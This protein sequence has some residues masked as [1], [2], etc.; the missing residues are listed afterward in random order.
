MKVD[1]VSMSWSFKR[2]D[3]GGD[4]SEDNFVRELNEAA[5]ANNIILFASLPD[6]GATA[7]IAKYVP[8]ADKNVIRIGSATMFGEEAKEIILA[9]RDFLLPGEEIKTPSGETDKG[10][11]YATAY[12]AGLAALVL[13]CLR[14]HKK[15]E[16]SRDKEN[17]P[18]KLS[19]EDTNTTKRLAEAATMNG[20]RKIFK[21]LSK[22]NANAEIPPS[23]FF[24]RPYLALN[25]DFRSN[26]IKKIEF[27]RN[28]GPQLLPAE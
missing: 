4:E 5:I 18:L 23:G 15:L 11:S 7:E 17:H 21:V 13:Y 19:Y 3:S 27:L 9:P 12:A 22:Q 2:N 16:D 8:V 6:K 20:M 1:I 28:L 24:V 25:S 26:D 10:S 14:A